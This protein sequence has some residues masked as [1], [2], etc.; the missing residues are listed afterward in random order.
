MTLGD[1]N[2]ILHRGSDG[3]VRAVE[4]VGVRERES[5]FERACPVLPLPLAVFCLVLNL[6]PGTGTL[7]AALLNLCFGLKKLDS[8]CWA[9]SIQ[10]LTAL[11]QVLTAPLL[12]GIVWSLGYGASLIRKNREFCAQSEQR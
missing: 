6:V 3:A 5:V 1:G 8:A 10:V 11:L 9:F 12:I 7:A 2:H 4:V